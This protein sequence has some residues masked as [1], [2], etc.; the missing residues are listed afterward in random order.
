[1][2]KRAFMIGSFALVVFL[3][4]CSQK[5][6]SNV[7]Q[8]PGGPLLCH[9]PGN[10]T[11]Y[12]LAD[13][14]ELFSHPGLRRFVSD[15]PSGGTG[16]DPMGFDAMKKKLGAYGVDI[17]QDVTEAAVFGSFDAPDSAGIVLRTT[18]TEERLREIVEKIRKE[19]GSPKTEPVAGKTAYQLDGGSESGALVY[20]ASDV[21]LIAQNSRTAAGMIESLARGNVTQAPEPLRPPDKT[22]GAI[23]RGVLHNLSAGRP[24]TSGAGGPVPSNGMT[25][26]RFSVA[27]VG[28]DRK[29][30]RLA[31]QTEFF[32]PAQ[33][34]TAEEGCRAGLEAIIEQA[35]DPGLKAGLREWIRI[36]RNERT[37]ML[38]A[39]IPAGQ[40]EALC[41]LLAA[42]SDGIGAA[43]QSTK[44]APT[45]TGLP[46]PKT[47]AVQPGASDVSARIKEL[48][49][50]F[51]KAGTREEKQAIWEELKKLRE[52]EAASK[53]KGK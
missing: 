48:S 41:A 46:T 6:E 19:G 40:T 23:L 4:G 10:V 28:P 14:K 44:P 45:G 30:L 1:M 12:V 9:V 39:E 33:A 51:A 13:V 49:D 43:P 27:S 38:D 21:V 35:G 18:V 17:E 52:I 26:A 15:P 24:S 53:S 2:L 50:R 20:L 5:P 8:G 32:D 37:L 25:Q 42:P 31:I 34:R 7:G 22:D 47:P 16:K 29:G 11:G 3:A 36:V